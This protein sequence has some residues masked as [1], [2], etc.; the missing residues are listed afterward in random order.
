MPES[1]AENL[2]PLPCNGS[3]HH[4]P[5][6]ALLHKYIAAGFDHFALSAAVPGSVAQP[7]QRNAVDSDPGAAFDAYPGIGAAARA[8]DAG[9][10]HP[11]SGLAVDEDIGRGRDGGAGYIVGATAIAVAVGGAVGLVSQAASGFGHGGLLR[12]V[13]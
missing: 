4:P 10:A 13:G 7:N 2:F 9:I 6:G 12:F 3:F 11:K 5:K 1:E 8:V